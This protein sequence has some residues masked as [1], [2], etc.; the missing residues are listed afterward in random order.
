MISQAIFCL[1]EWS[2]KRNSGRKAVL[3]LVIFLLP[4]A[5]WH[6]EN[7][8]YFIVFYYVIIILFYYDTFCTNK[9]SI[10]TVSE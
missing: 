8:F 1:T 3:S 2:Q 5:I 7:T 6:S 10:N 9:V 4:P